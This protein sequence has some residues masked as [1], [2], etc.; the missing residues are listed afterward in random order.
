M[1][2]KIHSGVAVVT[3]ASTGIGSVYADRLARRGYDLLL[4]A[5]NREGLESL[6][7]R[8]RKE[9]GRAAEILA[10]DLTERQN[11]A[12][13]EAR[14]RS[15]PKITLLVNNAGVASASPLGVSDADQMTGMIAL[16]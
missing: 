11:L 2:S 6:A 1:T 9:T 12:A 5:R 15:D 16:N 10:A 14:L 8:I 3:G 7:A 4:V 13:V